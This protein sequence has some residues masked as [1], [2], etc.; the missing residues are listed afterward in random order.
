MLGCLELTLQDQRSPLIEAEGL[1]R[2][3]CDGIHEGRHRQPRAQGERE[4]LGH[5]RAADVVETIVQS[6]RELTVADFAH[7]QDLRGKG[8]QKR[9]GGFQVLLGATHHGR[10]RSRSCPGGGPSHGC[11]KE[12]NTSLTQLLRCLLCDGRGRGAAVNHQNAF[13][14]SRRHGPKGVQDHPTLRQAEEHNVALRR[15]LGQVNSCLGHRFGLSHHALD[16]RAGAIK[17]EGTA[18]RLASCKFRH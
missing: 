1:P 16:S 13:T 12:A 18:L 2:S 4:H 15:Q 7:V 8:S 6:L 9:S 5:G 14:Q 17:K 3:R 10:E 11:I